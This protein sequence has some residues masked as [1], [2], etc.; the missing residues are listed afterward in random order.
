[1]FP[2]ASLATCRPAGSLPV[3]VAARTR[4]SSMTAWTWPDEM[5]SVWKAPSGN[6]A[7]RMMS[8]IASA[9]RG[10]L[11]ACLSRPTFPAIKAGAANRKTC[12]NGKFHGMI[13]STGPMGW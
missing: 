1:M 2:P 5:S 3:S 13:A 12:Q 10:T 9:H 6:P 7:R 8:S 11:E 4:G